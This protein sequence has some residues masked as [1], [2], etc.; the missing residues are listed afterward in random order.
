[1]PLKKSVYIIAPMRTPLGAWGGLPTSPTPVDLGAA[2]VKGTLHAAELAAANIDGLIFGCAVGIAEGSN[3]ARRVS[4]FGGI[5]RDTS[6][7]TIDQTCG[8][9]LQAIVNAAQAIQ[10]DEASHVIAAGLERN[11]PYLPPHSDHPTSAGCPRKECR[12]PRHEYGHPIL[13]DLIGKTAPNQNDLARQY[14]IRVPEQRRYVLQNWNRF[15]H[16]CREG[17][18]ASEIVPLP[19]SDQ[20]GHVQWVEQDELIFDNQVAANLQSVTTGVEHDDMPDLEHVSGSLRCAAALLV[21]NQQS[22]RHIQR[23]PACR[24]LDF[25]TA[26]ASSSVMEIGAT[27]AIRKLLART[28]IDLKEIDLIELH[29]SFLGEALA[30]LRELRL[31]PDKVN[32]NGSAA[33]AGRPEGSAGTKMVVTLTHEMQRREARFGL[34][35]LCDRRET[36]MAMLLENAQR[37]QRL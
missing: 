30:Y 28:G 11:L 20:N 37:Y 33:L 23:F 14:S 36:A 27:L 2:A 9:G 25:T 26:G 16:A 10:L 31:D 35:A 34:V 19:V 6:A 22:F 29:E 15:Q 8:A 4:H 24:I 12:T 18:L 21:T 32:V 7:Y 5:P 1:M 17:R 3:L 13:D